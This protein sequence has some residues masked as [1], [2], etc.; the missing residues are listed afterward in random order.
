MLFCCA[1]ICTL[2]WRLCCSCNYLVFLSYFIVLTG[3]TE[4]IFLT[5]EFQSFY[6]LIPQNWF[7]PIHIYSKSVE[8]FRFPITSTPFAW[9]IVLHICSVPMFSPSFFF[10]QVSLCLFLFFLFQLFSLWLFF[11]H[12][13]SFSFSCLIINSHLMFFCIYSF[14]GTLHFY[15]LFRFDSC[16]CLFKPSQHILLLPTFVGFCI[17]FK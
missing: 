14:L 4:H 8:V 16:S 17:C 13:I 5:F 2:F 3:N 1:L 12:F 10:L 6:Q 15:L 9:A 11:K 7:L